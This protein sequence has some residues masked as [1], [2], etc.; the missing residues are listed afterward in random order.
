MRSPSDQLQDQRLYSIRFFEPVDRRNVR[1]IERGK[2][3]RF[4]LE[5][6]KPVRIEQ[7]GIGQ[8]FDGDIAFQLHVPRAIHFSHSPGADARE[9]FVRPEP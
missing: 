5:A 9:N 2:D 1:M 3:V 6:R 8:D 4:P 7:E